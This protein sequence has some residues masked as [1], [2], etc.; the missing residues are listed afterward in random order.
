M[1]NKWLNLSKESMIEYNIK[2]IS[3]KYCGYF[4][5]PYLLHVKDEIGDYEC[6]LCLKDVIYIPICKRCKTK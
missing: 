3:C 6:N 4:K 2:P 5:T 1:C